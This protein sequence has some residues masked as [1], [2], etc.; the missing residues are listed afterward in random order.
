VGGR[1]CLLSYSYS[2]RSNLSQGERR[3]PGES[4]RGGAT[5]SEASPASGHD[6]TAEHDQHL[7]LVPTPV[8]RPRTRRATPPCDSSRYK[9]IAP[10][11]KRKRVMLSWRT[12]SRQSGGR[13][14]YPLFLPQQCPERSIGTV[15]ATVVRSRKRNVSQINPFFVAPV[16]STATA[17]PCVSMRRVCSAPAPRPSPARIRSMPLA[18]RVSLREQLARHRDTLIGTAGVTR[19]LSAG[20]CGSCALLALNGTVNQTGSY[21]GPTRAGNGI[22]V[23]TCR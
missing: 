4:P 20:L 3:T 8:R 6:S 7:R 23:S 14:G 2:Y 15:T 17:R 9:R 5:T 16:G 18:P 1:L 10:Q 12:T 19:T 11:E 22:S 13:R 21:H